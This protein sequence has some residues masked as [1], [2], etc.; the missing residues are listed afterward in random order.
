[1]NIIIPDNFYVDTGSANACVL[2]KETT[3]FIG[4]IVTFRVT[5]ANTGA[6]TLN[7]NS[8][9]AKEI[10]KNHDLALESGDLEAGMIVSVIYD[11]TYW[12]LLTPIA[13]VTQQQTESFIGARV[14][15]STQLNA[16]DQTGTIL[17]WDTEIFDTDNIH[18][19]TTNTDRLTCKT[20]GYYLII[21]CVQF[22]ANTTGYREAH[23]R[24]NGQGTDSTM[25][26]IEKVPAS[27]L[28]TTAVN[29]SCV[30]NMAVNDYV[31]L[32]AVQSSGSTLG[33][34]EL[35]TFFSMVKVG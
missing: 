35:M 5:N 18:D 28:E 33:I 6:T 26:A 8:F 14:K 22:L 17:T 23:V 25:P 32:V 20:A 9:G 29:L 27:P 19:N 16:A 7:V 31:T 4:E 21:G 30:I 1:M 12:Q 24:V 15:N 2:T 11:G 10:K 34:R 13:N 3:V